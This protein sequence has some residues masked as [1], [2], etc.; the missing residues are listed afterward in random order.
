MVRTASDAKNG[1]MDNLPVRRPRDNAVVAGVCAG[2]A[3]RW[4]VDPNLLRIAA[5][6]L[7]LMSGLGAVA[8]GVAVALLP[9]D[10]E[11]EAPVRRV[12]PF[13]RAWST[14]ALV[15]SV[16]GAGVGLFAI[17]GGFSSGM[18]FPIITIVGIWLLVA[19][20]RQ[21]SGQARTAEPTPY[22]R[23]AEAWQGRLVEHQQ[24]Q[25]ALPV[26]AAPPAPQPVGPVNYSVS[27]APATDLVPVRPRRGPARLWWLALGLAAGGN[28]AVALALAPGAGGAPTALAHLGVTVLSLGITL[29]VAVRRGRPRLLGTL[30]VLAMLATVGLMATT[31]LLGRFGPPVSESRAIT[32]VSELSTGVSSVAGELTYDL[33]GMTVTKDETVPLKLGAGD[34][35]LTLP[36]GV[37][38]QVTWKISAGDANVLGEKQDGLNLTGT[39]ETAGGGAGSPLLH[40][41]ITMGAGSLKVEQ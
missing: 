5:V 23:A 19:R 9:R 12:L 6:V 30:T 18:I 21:S 15:V 10:G 17:L 38:T 8:Y 28:A 29:L 33:S 11:T 41:V 27:N 36:K 26:V 1:R 35:K 31:P 14:P 7:A 34:V 16:I 3:R 24:R 2:L 13:T 25:G 39:K 40:L 4:N 32:S 37:R 22:E 20:R